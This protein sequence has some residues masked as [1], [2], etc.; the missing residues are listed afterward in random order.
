MVRIG[1]AVITYNRLDYLKQCLKTL[2]DNNWG[3]ATERIVIDDCSTDG[4]REWLSDEGYDYF[5]KDENKGVAN[6]KN[7]AMKYLMEDCGCDWIFLMEDDILMKD[8]H[9]CI[10][11]VGYAL[12]HDL[13]HL[14]FGLHG[15]M[16]IEQGSFNYEG[17]WC[18][19]NIVGAFS[20]YSKEVI[21]VVGYMDENFVNAWEHVEHTYRC[22]TVGYTT[23]FWQFADLPNSHELLVEI[24][25]SINHS[26]I[27][28]R[29]DWQKN[30]EQGKEYWIRKHG[31]WLPPIK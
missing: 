4:T 15:V 1:L 18:Y 19:P 5:S 6:N 17:V 13:Q 2:D 16:N 23:P 10:K 7:I 22:T 8:K 11:Y 24:L 30:I 28:P 27:R 14:N 26:S 9:T 25:G 3:G 31:T 21:E 12:A 20:L 29:D